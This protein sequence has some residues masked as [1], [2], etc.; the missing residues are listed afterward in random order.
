M[1]KYRSTL[2]V[3]LTIGLMTFAGAAVADCGAEH[4]KNDKAKAE[5]GEMVA[6]QG[7]L[8]V[9]MDGTFR[10]IEQESGESIELE[11]RE[12]VRI[13]DHVGRTVEVTGTWVDERG[14]SDDGS[15]NEYG[16]DTARDAKDKEGKTFKVS[17][18]ETVAESCES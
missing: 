16:S 7:C 5:K 14:S 3:A 6:L 13:G 9:E 10:L 4:A 15:G 18:I 17:R 12:E 2:V 11:A 1:R 8:S